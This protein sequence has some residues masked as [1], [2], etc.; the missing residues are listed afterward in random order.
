MKKNN[1]SIIC[2]I[3]YKAFLDILFCKGTTVQFAYLNRILDF[4]PVKYLFG[5]IIYIMILL[6][7]NRIQKDTYRFMIKSIF[8]L[9]GVANISIF[10]LRNYDTKMFIIVLV[11][12][13]ILIGL[14]IIFSNIKK[15]NNIEKEDI[16]ESLVYNHLNTFLFIIGILITIYEV[17]KFGINVSS[18]ASLYQARESFRTQTLS[19]IDSYLLSWNA[20][21][22]LPW[23]FLIALSN[24]KYF[25]CILVLFFALLMFEINGMKTWLVLYVIIV[26][27]VFLTRKYCLDSSI[28]II[29]ISLSIVVLISVIIFIITGSYELVALLDRTIILPGETN[30]YYLEFFSNN[31]LLLLRESIFKIFGKSPYDPISSVQIAMEYMPNAYYHNATN[32][33]I[34]DI[35][36]NFGFIGILLYPVMIF[37]TYVILENST[38]KYG[39]PIKSVVLF[40]LM[41]M[42]VNTSFFTWIMTGG[43]LIYVLILRFNKKIF[44]KIKK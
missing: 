39:R 37:T 20:T 36:G 34:G 41:W 8:M 10:G 11:F 9:S 29:L 12:W 15:D 2:F 14:C 13:I 40:I 5:W 42:L 22:I 19:T 43:F 7:I 23:C 21:V 18:F 33:L 16:I 38:K 1:I 6:M 26:A 25:R 24:K 27:F 3:I 4:N 35:Y 31:E 30:Y 17:K 28:N 44:I 32:G